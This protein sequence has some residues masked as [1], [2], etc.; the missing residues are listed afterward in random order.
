[1]RIRLP[2]LL[3]LFWCSLGLGQHTDLSA[4]D[5][6]FQALKALEHQE[7]LSHLERIDD[8]QYTQ[9]L[10]VFAQLTYEGFLGNSK[11]I[12]SCAPVTIPF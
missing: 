4:Y 12:V 8:P 2:G 7:A 10:E 6:Y 1:M 3:L 9:P 11:P 5:A